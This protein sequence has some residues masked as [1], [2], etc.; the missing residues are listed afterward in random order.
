MVVHNLNVVRVAVAPDEAQPPLIVDADAV[1]SDAIAC[2]R[3]QPI[4]GRLTEIFQVGRR[5][6]RAQFAAGHLGQIAR[7]ALRHA[8]GPYRRRALVCEGP[9][10]TA[11]RR[12]YQARVQGRRP[13]LAGAAGCHGAAARASR[14]LGLKCLI[15]LNPAPNWACTAGQ[16]NRRVW[17]VSRVPSLSN[18][19][20]AGIRTRHGRRRWVED[21]PFLLN[22][23][24]GLGIDGKRY[25][26]GIH[27]GRFDLAY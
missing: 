6:Q 27:E 9:D 23:N 21:N 1:L 14:K 15:S 13:P 10:H 26:E 11:L 4:A 24:S 16:E 3:L 12:A 5:R 8:V 20:A 2:Q 7:K 19:E 18:A 22:V 17:G 25:G